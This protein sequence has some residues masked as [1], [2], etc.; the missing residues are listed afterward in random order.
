MSY[1]FTRRQQR[2][3]VDKGERATHS[4]PVSPA[5]NSRNSSSSSLRFRAHSLMSVIDTAKLKWIS[6]SWPVVFI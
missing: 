2:L 6:P 1:L 4:C 3:R 5:M